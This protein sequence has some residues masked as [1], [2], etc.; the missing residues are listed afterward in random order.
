ADTPA[1]VEDFRPHPAATNPTNTITI[2]STRVHVLNPILTIIDKLSPN[3]HN[4]TSDSTRR[5]PNECSLTMTAEDAP[6]G[7]PTAHTKSRVTLPPAWVI[8]V[9]LIQCNPGHWSAR[10][11]LRD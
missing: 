8:F 3:P 7:K 11:Q 5:Q 6:A 1:E 10:A 2:S 9:L 4:P